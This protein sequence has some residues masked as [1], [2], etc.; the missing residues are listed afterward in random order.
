MTTKQMTTATDMALIVRYSELV[1]VLTKASLI[2]RNRI[3]AELERRV[4]AGEPVRI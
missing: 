4:L 3:N 2:E 1:P